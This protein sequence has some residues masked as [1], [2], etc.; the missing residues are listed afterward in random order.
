MTKGERRA[1]K[2]RIDS[3]DYRETPEVKHKIQGRPGILA[4]YLIILISFLRFHSAPSS[5]S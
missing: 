5:L 4:I 1:G 2:H 3:G